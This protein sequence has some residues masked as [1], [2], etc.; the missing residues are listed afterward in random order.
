MA[1]E[2]PHCGY[3][4]NEIQSASAVAEKGIK[5]S[6]RIDDKKVMDLIQDLNRQV[7]KSEFATARFE[8]LDFEIPSSTQRGILT[9]VDGMLDRA[10]EGLNQEQPVRQV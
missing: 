9:T 2:C 5:Q 3:K 8:E 1:F 6:C 10:I 4:N 7:V